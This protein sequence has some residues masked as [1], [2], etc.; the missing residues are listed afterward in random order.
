MKFPQWG[1]PQIHFTNS[2]AYD[3]KCITI[4]IYTKLKINFLV[5]NEIENMYLLF[6]YLNYVIELEVHFLNWKCQC[7]KQNCISVGDDGSKQHRP[8][9][10]KM[11]LYKF[12]YTCRVLY[13]TK[14]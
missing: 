11:G 2:L 12:Y 7:P 6:N 1:D 5:V 9:L 4:L 13:L 8:V 10:P 3:M 14:A